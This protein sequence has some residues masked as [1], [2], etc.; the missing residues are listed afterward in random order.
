MQGVALPGHLHASPFPP[1]S[2]GPLRRVK[3]CPQA[4]APPIEAHANGIVHRDLKP[5]N[6]FLADRPGLP[7][8]LKVLD[9]GISKRTRLNDERGDYPDML[10]LT[11]T[12]SALGSPTYMSPEQL[13]NPKRV[14]HRT[15]LWSLGLT[16]APRRRPR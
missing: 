5:S 6:L 13:R 10:T 15:D 3:S 16:P 9:F 14:D 12:D 8:L 4:P 2:T 1:T 7:P 11:A